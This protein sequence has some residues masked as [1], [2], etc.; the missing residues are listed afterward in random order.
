MSRPTPSDP[1]LPQ[2][3]YENLAPQ[4]LLYT[5]IDDRNY[6]LPMSMSTPVFIYRKDLLMQFTGR[7]GSRATANPRHEPGDP[8]HPGLTRDHMDH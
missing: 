1:S 6:G 4:S 3:F 7:D 2:M 5:R 8:T